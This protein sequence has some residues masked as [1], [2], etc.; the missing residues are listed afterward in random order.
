MPLAQLQ[1]RIEL[2][3]SFEMQMQFN[4]RQLSQPVNY[5]N[6]SVLSRLFA[7]HLSILALLARVT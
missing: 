5:V 4:L 1:Q 3:R 7:R 6:L 2:N